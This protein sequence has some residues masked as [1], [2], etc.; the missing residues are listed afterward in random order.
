MVLGT[1]WIDIKDWSDKAMCKD[2]DTQIFFPKRGEATRPIKIICSVCP[3]VKPCL[4]YAMKSSEKFGVWGGTSERER[5]RIRG[6]RGRQLRQGIKLPLS[7]L[8]TMCGV[9]VTSLKEAELVPF[10]HE[11]DF[12]R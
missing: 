4:E 7:R 10:S 12:Y 1:K 5:R 2:L 11:D 3:V 9:N 8:M 6:M